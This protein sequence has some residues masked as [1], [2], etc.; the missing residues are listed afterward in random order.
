MLLGILTTPQAELMYFPG[1]DQW[2]RRSIALQD[3]L[4]ECFVKE[5]AIP[6]ESTLV[7]G[8]TT[9]CTP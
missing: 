6:D 7:I 2:W 1:Q 5:C 9:M 4:D 8:S 3:K